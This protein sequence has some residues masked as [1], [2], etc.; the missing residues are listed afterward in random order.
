MSIGMSILRTHHKGRYSHLGEPQSSFR[1]S[2][3]PPF[4]LVR[5]TITIMV[6]P[7]A[8]RYCELIER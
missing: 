2:P 8:C 6:V 4:G 1:A 3:P 7:F 5:C